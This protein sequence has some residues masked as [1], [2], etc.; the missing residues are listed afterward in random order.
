MTSKVKLKKNLIRILKRKSC[1]GIACS[2]CPFINQDSWVCVLIN[3]KYSTN[4]TFKDRLQQNTEFIKSLN[5][6]T[7]E[8]LFLEML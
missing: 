5:L 2:Q 6:V 8:G 4:V 1:C 3:K 7:E